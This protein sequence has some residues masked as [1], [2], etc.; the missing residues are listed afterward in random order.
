VNKARKRL[1]MGEG[2]GR[3]CSKTQSKVLFLKRIA[4]G[5]V[6]GPDVRDSKFGANLEFRNRNLRISDFKNL[7]I[8]DF[9]FSALEICFYKFMI[10]LCKVLKIGPSAGDSGKKPGRGATWGL[11]KS[12]KLWTQNAPKTV[13]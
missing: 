6:L 7:K 3:K 11:S 1:K 13:S 10:Y 9:D 2:M 8:C 12:E 4:F 5:A